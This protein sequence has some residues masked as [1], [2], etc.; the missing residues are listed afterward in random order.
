MSGEPA[1]LRAFSEKITG[2]E[3]LATVLAYTSLMALVGHIL[4]IGVFVWLDIWPMVA[5][6]VVSCLVFAAC[7]LINQ[8][9][10][11]YLTLAI[12]MS[13][14]I[15]HAALAV[16]FVGWNSGFGAYIL[17]LVPLV[18]Y[19]ARWRLS[20]KISLSIGL[21]IA[22]VS[23][24]VYAVSVPP[25]VVIDQA[26]LMVTGIVNALVLFLVIAALAYVFRQ[27]ATTTESVLT[28]ANLALERQANTDPLTGLSNRRQ[29]HEELALAVAENRT[30]HHAFSIV[31]A[32]IDDF[33]ALNDYYGHEAGDLVLIQVAR[34]MRGS[35]REQDRVARWGGEEFM[36][37]L[38]DTGLDEAKVAAERLLAQIAAR[39]TD[40]DGQPLSVTLT[41]GVAEYD[42]EPDPGACIKRADAALYLGKNSGKNQ[43]VSLMDVL[44]LDRDRSC[45]D[46]CAQDQDG[47]ATL[48]SA[49]A[50]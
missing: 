11:T 1:W 44:N 29:M 47:A 5:F 45:D 3:N 2:R 14:I 37:L 6:N 24:Y 48:V 7:F 9:G 27:A 8:L 42:G 13:E 32:D 46:G 41:M 12:G 19:S 31:I 43:V 25:L 50:A 18:F 4:F 23:V 30:H 35:L 36:I 20:A 15:I 39:P 17:W 21:T 40:I 22:Y 10:Y 28:E 38:A 33:K 34:I 49:E 26:H 16:A